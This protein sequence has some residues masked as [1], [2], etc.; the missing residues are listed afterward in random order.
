MAVTSLLAAVAGELLPPLKHELAALAS[1]DP[2]TLDYNGSVRCNL[3]RKGNG[4]DDEDSGNRLGRKG[5][6]S[7]NPVP[8]TVTLDE[9]H[10][11]PLGPRSKLMYRLHWLVPENDI[12]DHRIRVCME[13]DDGDGMCGSSSWDGEPGPINSG[14]RPCKRP[15][16]LPHLRRRLSLANHLIRAPLLVLSSSHEKSVGARLTLAYHT[17][18]L[19]VQVVPQLIRQLR[20]LA[21][22]ML[23]SSSQCSLSVRRPCIPPA[24]AEAPMLLSA[25]FQSHQA[26]AVTWLGGGLASSFSYLLFSRLSHRLQQ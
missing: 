17:H 25:A 21:T 18:R 26:C 10:H 9:L 19:A 23:P 2:N 24:T 13:T 15:L 16:N 3:T 7:E 8:L 6:A 4:H 12:S 5:T 22:V 1:R 20:R 11:G 14:S